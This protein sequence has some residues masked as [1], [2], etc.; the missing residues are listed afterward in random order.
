MTTDEPRDAKLHY[1]DKVHTALF[2]AGQIQ[3]RRFV[4][5]FV[6]SLI[7]IFLSSGIITV[8]HQV[9]FAGIVVSA[10][11][12]LLLLATAAVVATMQYLD[13]S[14]E[15]YLKEL[16]AEIVTTYESLGLPVDNRSLERRWS[17]F[18]YPG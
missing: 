7:I 10:P 11:L 2:E 8:E 18:L 15:A 4:T 12:S 3:H 13:A 17:A 5:Y 6:L 9:A 16:R 1:I 14:T